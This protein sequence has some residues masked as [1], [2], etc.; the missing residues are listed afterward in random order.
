MDNVFRMEIRKSVAQLINVLERQRIQSSEI[1]SSSSFLLQLLR[2]RVESF[3]FA[4]DDKARRPVHTRVEGK[5]FGRRE[6]IH[7]VGEYSGV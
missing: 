4:F 1:A 7:R 3:P 5:F 6:K 2:T